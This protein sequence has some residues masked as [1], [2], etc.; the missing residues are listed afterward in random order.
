MKVAYLI[1]GG[2][3]TKKYQSGLGRFPSA[4]EVSKFVECLHRSYGEK[5][6]ILRIYFYD[7]PPLN[8]KKKLPISNSTHDFALSPIYKQRTQFLQDLRQKDYFAVREGIIKFRG[9]SPKKSTFN[10]IL[11]EEPLTDSDFAPDLEQKGVDIKIGL[12][13]ALLSFQKVVDRIYLV[14]ADLDFLPAIKV[15]RRAGVQ[16][17]L[18]TLRHGVFPQLSANSDIFIKDDL[19]T[20]LKENSQN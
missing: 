4:D 6:E 19:H 10:K 16:V 1:D 13:I 18:I 20:I 15:A 5:N 9:W 14:T 12:D 2:F 17:V 7:C 11:S 3:F 8:E